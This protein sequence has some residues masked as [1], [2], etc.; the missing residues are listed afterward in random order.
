MKHNPKMVPEQQTVKKCDSLRRDE[1][2]DDTH[3]KFTDG[4][5]TP[6]GPLR[7]ASRS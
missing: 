3:Q 7:Q 5:A 2:V 6:R 4:V 1:V